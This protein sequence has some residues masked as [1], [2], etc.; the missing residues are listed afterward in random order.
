[1]FYMAESRCFAKPSG[2]TLLKLKNASA[3]NFADYFIT[4][5]TFDYDL[6]KFVYFR[7]VD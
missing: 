6:S 3:T 7:I 5:D 4:G 2:L 1:M